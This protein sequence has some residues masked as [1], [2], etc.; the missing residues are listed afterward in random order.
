MS[1]TIGNLKFELEALYMFGMTFLS[2]FVE[3]MLL[4]R[5]FLGKD[6]DALL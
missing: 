3:R 1:K 6:E 5:D 4:S 2:D